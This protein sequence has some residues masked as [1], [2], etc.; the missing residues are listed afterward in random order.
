MGLGVFLFAAALSCAP[1]D[2]P[3]VS[4]PV[5]APFSVHDLDHIS[6]PAGAEE[7]CMSLHKHDTMPLPRMGDQNF[8]A[9]M[10]QSAA[11]KNGAKKQDL[12]CAEYARYFEKDYY[13]N[14]SHTSMVGWRI[15]LC[16]NTIHWWGATTAWCDSYEECCYPPHDNEIS[17]CEGP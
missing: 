2:A 14:A 1:V 15:R 7:S 16:D 11:S 3:A 13:S 5:N 4:N 9:Q 17:T 10:H 8:H 12:S 6:I